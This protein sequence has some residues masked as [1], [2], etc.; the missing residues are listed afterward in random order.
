[1][2]KEVIKLI[3]Q[4]PRSIGPWPRIGQLTNDYLDYSGKFFE[5]LSAHSIEQHGCLRGAPRSKV[6]MCT[7]SALISR[8]R[9]EANLES[10]LEDFEICEEDCSTDFPQKQLKGGKS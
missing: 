7:F 6:V 10:P 5:Y 9:E 1:M 4:C 3:L 2:E 8:S